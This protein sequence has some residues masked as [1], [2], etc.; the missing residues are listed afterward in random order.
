[1]GY[2]YKIRMNAPH[3]FL[4]PKQFMVTSLLQLKDFGNS[5][6]S[7]ITSPFFFGPPLAPLSGVATRKEVF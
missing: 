4:S 5:P 6:N 1:M 7:N 2:L 3:I